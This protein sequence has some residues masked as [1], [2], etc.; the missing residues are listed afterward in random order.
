MSLI[1]NILQENVTN[2]ATS[3]TARGLTDAPFVED[4]QQMETEG[5]EFF[6]LKDVAL[7]PLR[8]LEGFAQS[9]YNL[10]DFVVGDALPNW[11]R[12]FLGKSESTVG[13]L[14]EGATQ[15]LTAFIPAGG[16]LSKAGQGIGLI[17]KGAKGME[18]AGVLATAGSKVQKAAKIGKQV[19]QGG[20]A[21]FVAFDGQEMRLSNLIE[22]VPSLKNPVTEYLQARP[23]DGEIEG[24]FKNVIEGLFLE[25]GVQTLAPLFTRGVKAIKDYKVKV[26]AG[27]DPD[28]A[29]REANEALKGEVGGELETAVNGDL[30]AAAKAFTEK[31]EVAP[32]PQGELPLPANSAPVTLSNFKNPDEFY[33]VIRGDAAF[34]DIVE[35]G[36]VR[37]NAQTKITDPNAPLS[38]KIAARPTDFPSFAKGSVS[39]GYIKGD[40]NHYI[41]TSSDG[42]LK[43]STS[44]RHGR[45]STMFPT[46]E[47]GKHLKSLEG[48]KV[49]VYK[50]I[51]SGNYELVYSKGKLVSGSNQAVLKDAVTVATTT[52]PRTAEGEAPISLESGKPVELVQGGFD[53]V[54]TPVF[55]LLRKANTTKE[56]HERVV[57]LANEIPYEKL[58]LNDPKYSYEQ[59]KSNFAAAGMPTDYVDRLWAN[60]DPAVFKRL[61]VQQDILK[62][63][64]QRSGQAFIDLAAKTEGL[65]GLELK[66]AEELMMDAGVKFQR[67]LGLYSAYGTGGSKLMSARKTGVVNERVLEFVDDTEKG[68]IDNYDTTLEAIIKDLDEVNPEAVAPVKGEQTTTTT[69]TTAKTPEEI[70]ESY[71]K[72]ISELEGEL[73]VQRELAFKEPTGKDYKITVDDEGKPLPAK[74]PRQKTAK[75]KDLEG[76]IAFYKKAQTEHVQLQNALKEF[77]AVRKMGPERLKELEDLQAARNDL[78]IQLPPSRVKEVKARTAELKKKLKEDP[79]AKLKAAELKEAER[80]AKLTD[81]QKAKLEELRNQRSYAGKDAPEVE[82]KAIKAIDPE[83]AGL[84]TQIAEH[85][86]AI[87]EASDYEALV[88]EL[89]RVSGMTPAQARKEAFELK[90][91]KDLIPQKPVRSVDQLRSEINTLKANLVKAGREQMTADTILRR[92]DILE[93]GKQRL[94]SGTVAELK[95]TLALANNVD[96]I[97]KKMAMLSYAQNATMGRKMLNATHEFWLNNLFSPSTLVVNALGGI[98]ATLL[99]NVEMAVG[100]AVAG[101]FG[102]IKAQ[103]NALTTFQ[104]F[105]EALEASVVAMKT[106]D[107]VLKSSEVSQG[108][109]KSSTQFDGRVYG[110]AIS[111]NSFGLN[112]DSPFGTTIDWMGKIARTYSTLLVGQDE[113]MKQ[114]LYRQFLRNEFYAEG[115][116]KGIKEGDQLTKYVENKL[117]GMILEGG[118]MYNEKS[119]FQAYNA[120]AK[121]AGLTPDT[122][123]YSKFIANEYT[124][125]PFD[126]SKG[127]L[128]DAAHEY[129]LKMTFSNE[130]GDA[131]T[132]GV[133]KVLEAAPVLKF[134]LPFVKTPTNILKF[135]LDRSPLGLAKDSVLALTSSKYRDAFTNGTPAYRA[136]IIGR[137]TTAATAT[138]G[139][140]FYMTNNEGAITGGGPQNKEEKDALKATGWQPYS[141]RIGDKYVSYNRLDPIATP[142]GILADIL[143]FNKVN[144]PTNDSDASQALSALL[145]SMTYNLTDKSYLRGLNNLMN[146]VRDPETY[147]PKLLQDMVGGLVPNTLNQL[148]NT[149]SKVLLR[150]SRSVTDAVM[151]RIPMVSENL[152]PQRSFLGDPLYKDNPLGLLSVVS[153]VYVSSPKNDIVDKEIGTLLHGFTLP[154]SKLHGIDDLDMRTFVNDKGVQA[155][156]RYLELSGTTLIN[157]KNLRQTLSTMMKSPEYKA[158]PKDN[159][160]DQIGTSSPRITAINRIVKRFRNKAQLEMLGEFP[161][162]YQKSKEL[163][164]M[165]RDYRLGKFENQQ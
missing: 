48:S 129:S 38:A 154:P 59:V 117:S 37:T 112:P 72:R 127:V 140:A 143:E 80:L 144:A 141:I 76:K 58:D 41:I 118:K 120:K 95:R 122:L 134:V 39:E 116:Q 16:L 14:V 113:F 52:A 109:I 92:E 151:K 71:D 164:Q 3:A 108:S 125:N 82:A 12:R 138:A 62:N 86:A 85:K 105:H 135:G 130:A 163:T 8:G 60:P 34:Q 145:V 115:L 102:K 21:D 132:Q 4:D 23:D 19:L 77:E 46:D 44:M 43:P 78:K 114:I 139:L 81:A 26:N 110:G 50:H 162:L 25:A 107:S 137:M 148:Q 54:E 152:P 99:K 17:Q 101:D 150:E 111:S 119:L 153:P 104:G 87:K 98:T 56:L 75:E 28:V 156:D 88:K 165:Q 1:S 73:A 61:L 158:I 157:G 136:E 20:I 83:L 147:G 146:T 106:S 29:A 65:T 13:G 18:F 47:A 49:D 91:R 131:F 42:S 89:E 35:S 79:A 90:A 30:Y 155:Y 123:E 15:F 103:F 9:I 94:G 64:V 84:R 97:E 10:G 121:E 33:R 160:Q 51:G 45:G 74:K 53:A 149:E 70:Q 7:A 126:K 11:D 100:N 27:I 40:D 22:S 69:T 133:M 67:S 161:E 32:K 6:N 36:L 96:G 31:P 124:K 128:A 5:S 2:A 57:D 68:V 93:F 55:D 63:E 159:V 66:E 24:R 142:L